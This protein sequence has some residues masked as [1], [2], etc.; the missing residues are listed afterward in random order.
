MTPS[1]RSHF[2]MTGDPK[3]SLA[4][5]GWV[6]S[7]VLDPGFSPGNPPGRVGHIVPGFQGLEAEGAGIGLGVSPMALAFPAP[8]PGSSSLTFTLVG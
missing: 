7:T 5:R 2:D 8:Q 4:H 6:L 3:L 1:S